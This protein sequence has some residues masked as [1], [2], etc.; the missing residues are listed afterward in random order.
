MEGAKIRVMIYEGAGLM[1]DG[2]RTVADEWFVFPKDSAA[3][4]II[5]YVEQ[6]KAKILTVM[7]EACKWEE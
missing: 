5:A 1:A 6:I 4:D 2:Q 3:V 7:R